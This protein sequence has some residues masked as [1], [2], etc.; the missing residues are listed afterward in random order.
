MF[1]KFLQTPDC[2]RVLSWLLNHPDSEYSVAIVGIECD[3][4]DMTRYMAVISILEGIGLITT[5]DVSEE[6][7]IKLNKDESITQ[8]LLHL[9]DEFNDNAFRS[10]HVS[11]SLA[12]LHS[13][14]LKKVVDSEI[15]S[16]LNAEDLIDLCKN[17]K[18]L[19]LSDPSNNDIYN[20]CS[21]L[22]ETG[23]YED[24]INRLEHGLQK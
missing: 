4:V 10:E 24:F 6:I 17:Y 14:Q 2:M 15:F 19:D 23:E 13:D 22:E 1:E 20:L 18:D 3:M 8:L 9:K 21:K 11:P 12:Y 5:D 16:S 7:T